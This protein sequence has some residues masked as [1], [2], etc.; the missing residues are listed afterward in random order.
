MRAAPAGIPG[1]VG[2]TPTRNPQ[3]DVPYFPDCGGREDARP[4]MTGYSAAS[5]FDRNGRRSLSQTCSSAS[6]S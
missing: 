3:A 5:D 2:S 1:Y 4:L 6:A